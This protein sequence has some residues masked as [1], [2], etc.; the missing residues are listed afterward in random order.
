MI[1]FV[2]KTFRKGTNVYENVNFKTG[3]K[4]VTIQLCTR[5]GVTVFEDLFIGFYSSELLDINLLFV[6]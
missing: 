4:R 5:L 3:G 6:I 2:T 1:V